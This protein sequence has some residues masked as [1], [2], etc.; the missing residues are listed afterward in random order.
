MKLLKI[1]F[2]AQFLLLILFACE[3]SQ[4]TQELTPTNVEGV[5]LRKIGYGNKG[6]SLLNTMLINPE[7]GLDAR[8]LQ[9]T[10]DGGFTDGSDKSALGRVVRYQPSTGETEYLDLKGSTGSWAGAIRGDDIYLGSHQTGNFYHMKPN[11]SQLLKIQIPRPDGEVFDFIWS[12][13]Y[14]SDGK[15]YLGTYPEGHLLRYDPGKETFENLG[16]LVETSKKENYLR[17]VNG[18]FEG[19][20]YGG[21]GTNAHLV[22]YDIATGKRKM[23]L[24]KKYQEHSFVYYSDRFRDLLYAVVTPNS[25]LLFFDQKTGKFLREV[26]PPEGEKSFW[27][28]CYQSMI[29]AGDDLYFGTTPNDH[30]YRYNWDRDE[31]TLVAYAIGRPFGLAQN[32][33]L[34]CRDYFG[35][36]SI[37][38]LEKKEVVLQKEST[39]EGAGMHIFSIAR[40]KNNDL[41]GGSY[42]NQGY[43]EYASKTDRITSFG[44]SVKFGGQIDNLI[45]YKGKN[46]IAH[47]TKARLTVYDPASP[48]EPGN[49]PSSN[50]R[51]L[52]SVGSDQDRFPAAHLGEDDKLYFGTTPI[53]GALGG[54]LVILDPETETSEVYRNL[55][56]DQTIHTLL[57]DGAGKLYG[58]TSVRGGFGAHPAATSAKLFIWDMES[59]KKI[60]ERTII[61]KAYEILDLTWAPNGKLIGASD[62]TLFVYDV[63]E[64]KI[65]KTRKVAPSRITS[66]EMS[67]DGWCYGNTEKI[68]FRITPD[69]QNLDIIDE[70]Q[71]YW[72]GLIE[73]DNN[74]LYVTIGALLYEIVRDEVPR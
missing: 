21:V 59:K 66:L 70:Q 28:S 1:M 31:T 43:F 2:M 69:L 20:I 58:A 8:V 62:S 37:Y 15:V 49:L 53:Y 30:L 5:T 61:D 60:H 64:D 17:H 63:E 6:L 24:P 73:T 36:F 26:R 33:Y 48:W 19:K 29:Q 7:K 45:H 40:G 65:V 23:L 46:Y 68:L 34:Y 74:R 39:F 38:D 54:A 67:S 51:S 10:H 35:V 13:D 55:V 52:G 47:Y 3:T 50:P 42:I 14:G 72:R 4:K 56:Q 11:E 41:I 22:E 27:L 57:G 25:A 12:L 71:G 9:T 44:P 32:R 18:K 16:Q